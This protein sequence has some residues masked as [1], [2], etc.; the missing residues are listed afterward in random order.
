MK[1][2]L[3]IN[4]VIN[5][6][7]TGRITEEIGQVAL[8]NGWRSVIA[9]GRNNCTS[10]SEKIQIGTPWDVKIHGLQTRLFDR[11][12]L[13]SRRATEK[14]I[15]Q[16]E[17]IKPNV[18]HLHNIHGYYLNIE[19]LFNYLNK[20][21]IPVVWTLHDC[22]P[23]TGHCV[24]FTVIGCERWKSKCYSCPQ[25]NK[26]P[27]SIGLD[28]SKA[29]YQLKKKIFTSLS[30]IE[31][32][33]VSSWL[34]GVVSESFFNIY[35]HRFIYNGIDLD[36]FKPSM[37][38][39][40]IVRE[41]YKIR[42]RFLLLGVATAWGEGKGLSDYKQLS[43]QLSAN[44]VIVLLGL[45]LSLIKKLP[46]NIIG[47]P[48]TE[49]KEELVALYS[50]A[51]VVLNLS[52]EETFGLTTAEGFAC[53]TPGVVY[54]C[55]ASPELI[56]HETGFVVPQGDIAALQA[57]IT[58]IKTKGKAYYTHACR[59]RAEQY[60]NKNDRYAEYIALYEQLIKK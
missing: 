10:V 48:R 16:I 4:T 24:H 2:L 31:I 57:V 52:R 50:A 54:N 32:V 5:S 25:K 55:T 43:V 44:E 13:G 23:M 17:K 58:T 1:T 28:R 53:G 14:L 30:K 60:Y 42:N 59:L 21:S 15:E 6:G 49:S 33:S 20:S 37:Q 40:E 29:N 46:S 34:D 56:T 47:I 41:R 8:A 36:L 26:Y 18:I 22:W 9:F 45:P 27:G 12:G 3:Q 35:P 19:V 39:A 7:S 11:H 51:D 38:A